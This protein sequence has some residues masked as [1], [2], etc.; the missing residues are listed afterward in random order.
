MGWEGAKA[1][2]G[3]RVRTKNSRPH[4][5][6]SSTFTSKHLGVGRLLCRNQWQNSAHHR[7]PLHHQSA[8]L[9]LLL[10]PQPPSGVL[11]T[12]TTGGK[13]SCN[14]AHPCPSR[15]RA[16]GKT[17]SDS[18]PPPSDI[19]TSMGASV[20]SIVAKKAREGVCASHTLRSSSASSGHS[21]G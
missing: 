16:G 19:A 13:F 11:E 3:Q 15:T 21:A 10:V 4:A 7:Q 14:A 12:S 18:V 5:G 2:S 6:D 20:R 1:C 17:L 9:W 8:G